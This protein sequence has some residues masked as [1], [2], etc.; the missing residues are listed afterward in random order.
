[1]TQPGSVR[2]LIQQPQHTTSANPLA[3]VAVVAVLLL[4]VLGFAGER[5]TIDALRP[6]VPSMLAL[7]CFGDIAT[8]LVMLAL[9]RPRSFEP[10]PAVIGVGFLVSGALVLCTCLAMQTWPW[11]TDVAPP[12][13][14]AGAWLILFWH[15]GTAVAGTVY[16]RL[17]SHP[18]SAALSPAIFAHRGATIALAYVA[19]A[20]VVSSA[21]GRFLPPFA[22]GVSLVSM[23][24]C[25]LGLVSVVAI[26]YAIVQ[27]V[28]VRPASVIDR[29]YAVSLACIATGTALI[30]MSNTRY[31]LSWYA[32]RMLFCA[33]SISVLVCAMR[34]LL[35]WRWNLDEAE[36]ALLRSEDASDRR[37]ERIRTLRR[38]AA[39]CAPADEHVRAVLETAATTL[40][41]GARTCA[42]L[43]RVDGGVLRVAE[44]AWSTGAEAVCAVLFP[45]AAVPVERTIFASA[46]QTS[47]TRSWN[48]L[49]AVNEPGMICYELGW[50][51]MLFAPVQV[52][53]ESYVLVFGVLDTVGCE[54]F[55]DEDEAYAEVL[56]SFIAQRFSERQQRERLQF[57][58]EHD[59]LTGLRNRAQFR[60]ALRRA[61]S[62]ARPFVL[63]F[64]DLHDFR[65]INRTF[66]QMI[67]DEV[68]VEVAV[69]I[70]GTDERDFVARLGGDKF[71]ILLFDVA[72]R[73]DAMRR[74]ACYLAHFD[75]PFQSGDRDGT[76]R[77]DVAAN[78]GAAWF[79]HDGANADE[80][81]CSADVALDVAKEQC[82]RA[83]V[84]FDREMSGR[85]ERVFLKSAELNEAIDRG[86]LSLLYQPTFD[87]TTRRITGAE[88]LVR[89]N[90]PVLGVVPP[91][92]F[93][94]F[95]ER[96]GI[97][98]RLSL[99]V[100]QRLV[101]DLSG[102]EHVPDGFRCYFNLA[103]R[104]IDDITL[105][106]D[107]EARLRRTPGINRHIGIEI[108]E[109]AAIHNMESAI[110]ALDRFRKLGLTLAIDDFGT[111]YSSLSYLKRLPVDIIKIDRSF[112]DDVP[113]DRKAVALCELLLAAADRFDLTALAEG[114]ESEAQLAWL[115]DAGCRSGQGFLISRPVPFATM[116]GMLDAADP[117]PQA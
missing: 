19:V 48:A 107:L 22:G 25:G 95:A 53:R 9:C 46:Q 102:L 60:A 16:A 7:T 29:A 31:D 91:S 10:A 70:G 8:G 45:G 68:L 14:E 54:P 93:I 104:Q 97:I 73:D 90:H 87:L 66:G 82:C 114:I 99:W 39:D 2:S 20:V 43:A 41:A 38:L 86:G 57:Q 34:Q 52:G 62:D 96:N 109:T 105:I 47:H 77:I 101:D 11:A 63:A 115:R 65:K 64:L 26:V 69:A 15:V 100:M 50:Q 13:A 67:A 59:P 83:V 92:D 78:L 18:P 85:L 74:L 51:R 35:Q 89:W 24:T 6:F 49:G 44:V 12:S 103:T 111:G 72:S 27:I 32:A 33:S 88:A 23:R 4:A 113:H 58:I 94:E 108:T 42:V 3:V 37:A 110:Y 76:R 79:P 5:Y 112:V 28:R 40:R 116:I 81:M 98:G 84:L 61:T 117:R 106:D 21:L 56:A 55:G 36:A 30:V 71:A 80:L 17:R 75:R 1:M